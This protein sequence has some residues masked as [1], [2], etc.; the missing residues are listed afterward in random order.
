MEIS[1]D[2]VNSGVCDLLD[3][4]LLRCYESSPLFQVFSMVN[5][6]DWGSMETQSLGKDCVIHPSFRKTC[7]NY[8][9]AL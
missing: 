3:V 5:D 8:Y 7:N 4:P 2:A 9:T 1:L 6:S